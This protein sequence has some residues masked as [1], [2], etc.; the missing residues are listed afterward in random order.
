M[1]CTPQQIYY[2]SD[3]IKYNEMGGGIWQVL[4]TAEVHKV[5]WWGDLRARDCSEYLDV[6]GRI[7]LK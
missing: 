5:F 4:E 3:K 6:E 2:S 7:I 1:I